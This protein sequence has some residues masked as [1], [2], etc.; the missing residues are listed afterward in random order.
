MKKFNVLYV[1]PITIFFLLNIITPAQQNP[2]KINKELIPNAEKIM[3]LEFTDIQRDSMADELNDQLANYDNIRKV[4]LENSTPP[5][6]LFN[7]IP[8]GFIFDKKQKPLKFSDYSYV[9]MPS[10]IDDL[11][12][13]SVGELAHLIKTKKV[14]STQLT[15]M[16]LARL[17]KYAPK[18]HCVI[19]FTEE[20]ALK[21]AKKADDEMKKGKYRGMLHG[22]PFGVKDLLTSKTYKTTWGAAPYKDQLIDDDA[23]VIKK[24]EGAGAVLCAKLSMGELA[25]DDVW[26]GGLT[27]NPWDTTKGSSGS[28]A[29]SASSV[30]A[31]LLPFAIGTETWGSIVSPSTICGVTGLRPTYGRVSR[32]GA[33]ALSWSMDKIGAICR[34][35]E[36]LAIVFNAI[37]GANKKDKTLYEAAFNYQP[38]I[39]LKKLKIGYLKSDFAK[40]YQFH[41]NDSLALK[42]FEELGAKLIPIE[43][44]EIAT[45]DISIILTAEAAAAFDDLTRSH[46]DDMLARQFKGAWPNIFRGSR[47]IP[48]VEYINASRIRYLLIQEMQKLMQK[49][50][51]YLA[52]SLEGNNLLLTNL[53]GNPCVVVPTG[54]VDKST[55]SSISF[56]GRLFDE[57]KL[58]AVAKAFQDATDFHKKHPKLD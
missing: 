11:A 5:A 10:N 36:D 34:N 35:T 26:F 20:R 45:N 19:S 1:L 17:K 53:T 51:V 30:S 57:G 13:Y 23:T 46:K 38:K 55:L 52:P 27:R 33:M 39:D 54:F 7:P 4:H 6:F 22:I 8:V 43:I 2:K 47:F 56:T 3:G 31:G 29:G 48:A 58:I 41:Q 14:T 9:K 21:Q 42:R 50:D 12:F 24:L 15:Q 32:T 44:P 18:L 28:S 49:I 40:K 25:M 16:Y 37:Q